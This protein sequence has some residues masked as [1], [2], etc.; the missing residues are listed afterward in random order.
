M[1]AGCSE[2]CR[3]PG[4]VPNGEADIA[5]LLLAAS[6]RHQAGQLDA[7]EAL[8]HDVLRTVPDEPNALHLLGV[9]A[10]QRGDPMAAIALISR[11]VAAMPDVAD[12]H[13]NLGNALRAAGRAGEAEKHCR[14]AVELAPDRAAFHA[15]LARIRN[16]LQDYEGALDA[17]R[18]AIGLDPNSTFAHACM[19]V[20]LTALGRLGEARAEFQQS[21]RLD[22]DQPEL[23][24]RFASVLARLDHVDAAMACHQRA[25]SLRPS[26]PHL[27][28]ARSETL[29]SQHDV[30]AAVEAARTAT[31][32]APDMADA[33][34]ALGVCL[35]ALGRFEEAADSFRHALRIDP[36]LT[37]AY[38][39]LMV[40]GRRTAG[41]EERDRLVA[42]LARP[43]LPPDRRIDAGIALGDW[44]DQAGEYDPAF[45]YYAEA[46]A[47][48]RQTMHAK[49]H[50]FDAAAL[51]GHVD[52]LIETFT[53]T[54]FDRVADWGNR[55]ELP[56][57]AV[58]MPRSGS[59]LV[60]QILV[61][62]SRVAGRGE[63]RDIER[64]IQRLTLDHP[65]RTAAD[66]SPVAA[67]RQADAYV[68]RLGTLA[69]GA[70]R[71]V[72]KMPDNVFALGLIAA[73]FPAVSILLCERDPRDVCLS[74][75][76]QR[77]ADP[78]VFSL[79]LADCARR[80]VE[81]RRLMAH[82]RAVLPVSVHDVSYEALVREP[83][84]EIRRLVACLGLD[85]EEACLGFHLTDRP[86]LTASSWQV[87]QPIYSGSVGRWRNYA[88]HMQ[89]VLPILDGDGPISA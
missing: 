59:T 37:S 52:A 26:D 49:G 73:L 56:V 36:A 68:A 41:S 28:L 65:G 12:V 23:L 42:L 70:L 17:C 13:G 67:R 15:N 32:L 78:Q 25:L 74:C 47:L 3:V 35:N 76:F 62:H 48:A 82:W 18:H 16:D 31:S 80:V 87:R 61:S 84:P 75:Y 55:S 29:F 83:G 22:P 10:Y 33:W 11:A 89:A 45:Q 88:R 19:A 2:T 4:I 43:D 81:V 7:A 9:I 64:L 38:R 77:F 6:A 51:R 79:D 8:Y 58:G 27:H 5:A 63:P 72:D 66:W 57:F 21:L 85:W 86:V 54:F 30:A 14:R 40:V 60:E 71:V 44:F 53:P 46:N 39:G 24:A 1:A 34:Q 20:A 69:P 50:R